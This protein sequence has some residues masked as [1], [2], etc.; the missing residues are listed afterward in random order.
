MTAAPRLQIEDLRVARGGTTVLDDIAF[1]IAPG[2][3]LAL[4]GVNGAGKSSL[5]RAIAGLDP[6]A[7]R[8]L[9]DDSDIA[10]LPPEARH[11]RGIGLVPEGRRVFPGMTVRENLEIA[12]P[13]NRAAR[14]ERLAEVFALFPDLATKSGEAA[15]RLSGG[16]QQMLALGR[17]L[18]GRPCLLL[19]D[20]PSLG[21]APRLIETLLDEVRRIAAEGVA[22][23]LAEQNAPAALAIADSAIVLRGGRIADR[24]PAG[25]FA[26]PQRLRRALLGT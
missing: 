5:I 1:G 6:S 9:L 4:L 3:I 8:I 12:A 18:A 23:L 26:E 17:A 7:G 15:W 2:E 13:G 25:G 20:E 19:M 11:H 16:Q 24:G 10:S 14:R 22:V 21:L